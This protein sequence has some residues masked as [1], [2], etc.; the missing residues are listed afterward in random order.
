MKSIILENDKNEIRDFSIT[1]PDLYSMLLNY[2][3]NRE[4]KAVKFKLHGVPVLFFTNSKEIYR[5]GYYYSPLYSIVDLFVHLNDEPIDIDCERLVFSI[6]HQN[7]IW[8]I[9]INDDKYLYTALEIAED[10]VAKDD[11]YIEYLYPPQKSL[12]CPRQIY[13]NE[14]QSCFIDTIFIY[15]N[16]YTWLGNI[17][18][19]V[20][21]QLNKI[22][23][24]DINTIFHTIGNILPRV[25]YNTEGVQIG[26]GDLFF[27]ER[28][29]V[30]DKYNYDFKSM[31]TKMERSVQIIQFSSFP[32]LTIYPNLLMYEIN[33]F[34]I[35]YL[36]PD[37]F[38]NLLTPTKE[39]IEEYEAQ[40]QIIQNLL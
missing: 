7:I 35:S 34:D 23:F 28:Q 32:I 4:Y 14:R 21:F 13:N 38:N 39:D 20:S 37:Y 29:V 36:K 8:R 40:K 11:P 16:K 3:I 25:I 12:N 17:S 18:T 22:S 33:K 6:L 10:I 5:R 15:G 31:K 19:L 1:H 2:T 27:V 30:L 26:D 9:N 24:A